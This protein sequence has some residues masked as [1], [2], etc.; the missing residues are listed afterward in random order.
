MC[1]SVNV[2][3]CLTIIRDNHLLMSGHGFTQH[4]TSMSFI[5]IQV[6]PS[7]LLQT[8]CISFHVTSRNLTVLWDMWYWYLLHAW[9]LQP[10]R[11]TM[12]NSETKRPKP[13]K[14]AKQNHRNGW[15]E[16]NDQNETSAGETTETNETKYQNKTSETNKTTKMKL[17]KHQKQANFWIK[18]YETLPNSVTI[19]LGNVEI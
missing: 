15:N 10:V 14:W 12:R 11:H 5:T 18:S 2:L 4:D 1:C 7:S 9:R 6:H 17:P 8:C 19:D 3:F 16:Q 13:P